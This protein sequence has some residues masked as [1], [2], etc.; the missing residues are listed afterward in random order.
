M[1][2]RIPETVRCALMAVLVAMVALAPPVVFGILDFSFGHS[3][4]TENDRHN[5]DVRHDPHKHSH[6]HDR[7]APDHSHEAGATLST[8]YALS[9][10]LPGNWVTAPQH[11]VH[12]RASHPPERPPRL[13]ART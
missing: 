4:A 12:G 7:S 13:I 1:F 10:V 2:P 3:A 9:S 8:L 6:A 5:D 11:H